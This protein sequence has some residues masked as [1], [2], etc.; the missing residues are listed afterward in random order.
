MF[1]DLYTKSYKICLRIG[2]VPKL[3]SSMQFFSLEKY[4]LCAYLLASHGIIARTKTFTD[5]T[6]SD[7]QMV[8][9][10][11]LINYYLS[12]NGRFHNCPHISAGSQRQ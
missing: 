6:D 11:L 8:K 9:G 3:P 12:V 10:Y 4:R 5:I 1:K 2:V 7:A